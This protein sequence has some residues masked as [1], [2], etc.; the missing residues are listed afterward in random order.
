[1]VRL[2]QALLIFFFLNF[3]IGIGRVS[4]VSTLPKTFT[5]FLNEKSP[6]KNN[7]Y[8][9]TLSLGTWH[10]FSFGYLNNE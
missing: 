1:M 4:F 7:H 6:S 3:I 2:G 10:S 5:I 8:V 9:T